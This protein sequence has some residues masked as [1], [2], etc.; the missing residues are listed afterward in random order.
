V[1]ANLVGLTLPDLAPLVAQPDGDE[2]HDRGNRD[3]S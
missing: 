2:G 3:D 1:V